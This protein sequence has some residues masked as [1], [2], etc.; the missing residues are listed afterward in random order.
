LRTFDN[1]VLHYFMAVI[2][3]IRDKYAK[4]AGGIIVVALVGFILTDFG[5]TGGRLRS[6]SIGKINGDKIEA[7]EY[8]AAVAARE[9]E[10]KRQNPNSTV[11]DNSRAQ[12]R[13]QVWNDMVNA[14]LMQDVNEKLGITVTKAEEN[15][16]LTGAN[17]DPAVKQNFTNPQTGVF[18]PQEVLQTIAQLKKDPERKKDWDA[19]EA[20]M[21][22]RR[23]S[24]KF[25]A[26]VSGAI[27]TPKFILDDI[28]ESRN[29]F[30]KI[31]YVKLP[32]TLIPDA[33]VKV[34]DEDIKQ[35]MDKHKTMFQVKEATRGVEFVQ[36]SIVPSKE[37]SSAT[38]TQ[39]DK[40]KADFA[41]S[42][43]DEA[44]V[45]KNSQNQIP[46]AFFT[47]QQLQNLPNV[48]ELMN[49]PIGSIVGPFYDGSNYVL[50][51]VKDS[52]SLPDSV[53]IRHILVA[54]QAAQGKTAL[55][56]SAAKA[57]I[58]S[59]AVF[60]KGGV[61]IDSLAARYSDDPSS[62]NPEGNTFSLAQK[63]AIETQLGEE[64]GNFV[65]EGHPGE[66]KIIKAPFGYFYVQ[67]VKQG[68]P[69]NSVKFAFISKEL[70]ISDNTNNNLYTKATQFSSQ[71]KNGAA[72][73][74]AAKA[75]G[76]M[77]NP[78]D[79]LN[80]NS[81]MVNGLGSSRDLVKWAYDAKMGDVS[82]VYTIN[83]KYVV[84]KLSSMMDAGLAPINDKTR[85][86]LAEYVRKNKKA[87]MLIAKANKPASLEAL[88]QSQGQAVGLADSVN[89][90]QGFVPGL[91]NEAKVAGYAFFKSF[92][93][94][95]VSAGIAGQ[96]GVYFIS[97]LSKSAAAQLAPRNMQMERQMADYQIKGS[98]ANQVING[99]RD[100]AEVKDTRGEIY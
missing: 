5:K 32:Y 84:A 66:T 86:I 68:A 58:D 34:S 25:N 14:R 90:L 52:K 28:N 87:E 74:K 16:L 3:K 62:K 44:F 18:N 7:T 53:T 1:C 8:D 78:A 67:I 35:Y 79:G 85:P 11:D 43:D 39:L 73:D 91:G 49:A 20:D 41:A 89:F 24:S 56:D 57:R 23:Y 19:F 70:N 65:F 33:S 92:K 94:N 72:F 81:Y 42:T 37:D 2:Q 83:N 50:A 9:A 38:L 26:L 71:A 13:D 95:T 15:D 63:S 93:E 98:A 22:K 6:T 12:L 46:V 17:P 77:V 29:T 64:Y 30:A 82:P 80:K 45:N 60:A 76:Y 54:T 40:I 99:M 88:A 31:N 4:L 48:D 69:T 55:S 61:S 10:M 59:V 36:F 100:A 75:N 96:E 47:K 21:I 27:Y 97:L 51:K